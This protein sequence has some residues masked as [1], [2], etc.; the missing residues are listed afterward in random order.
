MPRR[1]C[2]EDGND[3][4]IL[5]VRK[6]KSEF[7]KFEVMETLAHNTVYS[8]LTDTGIDNRTPNKTVDRL[9]FQILT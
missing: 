5:T 4:S 3:G 9:S 7:G 1:D 2:H 8:H 6:D